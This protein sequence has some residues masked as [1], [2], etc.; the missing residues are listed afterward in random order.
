MDSTFEPDI[1]STKLL[2]KLEARNMGA[3]QT[4]RHARVDIEEIKKA[5]YFCKKYHA[6]Q[7][8]N[9][10]EPYYSHPITVA[11]MVSDYIFRTDIIVTSI[12][13]DTIEDTELTFEMIVESFGEL[14]AVQV[15]NLTRV[16]S[17]K[18]ISSAE[19]VE[20]L[21]K[22]KKYDV[23]LIKLFD[24]LH[25][26]RTI[27]AKSPEKTKKIVEETLLIFLSLAAYLGKLGIEKEIG[28]LC[29]QTEATD[30]NSP[31]EQENFFF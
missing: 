28:E 18:K 16:K 23:L 24:R 2:T 14:V 27:K 15:E 22:Q 11:D 26:M 5:I 4:N 31:P 3:D 29:M 19:M 12:L 17:G 21:W 13:H 9:S 30:P 20:S 25:N 7:K 1:W 8:R 10:G 6:D